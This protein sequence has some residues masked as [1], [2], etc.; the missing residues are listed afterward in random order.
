MD[1]TPSIPPRHDFFFRSTI[2]SGNFVANYPVAGLYSSVCH[3]LDNIFACWNFL[4]WGV[5]ICY[6]EFLDIILIPCFL[7]SVF[8]FFSRVLLAQ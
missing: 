2:Y 1:N 5:S 8:N 7:R 6:Y 3:T 4:D